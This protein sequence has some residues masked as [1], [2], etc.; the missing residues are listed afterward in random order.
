MRRHS[1]VK[2][3]FLVLFLSVCFV[4]FPG[5]STA[6][7]VITMNYSNFFPAPHKH[8]ILAEQWC[9]EIEKRTNG[10]VKIA[11]FPGGTLTPAAQIY[12]G[13]VKG[14]SDIGFSCFA[15]TRGKFPLTEVIDL[16]IG[17]KDGTTATRLI[18]EYYK[19]FKPKEIDEVKV[20]YLHAHGPGMLHTK[21]P[22][23]KLEDLKGMKI[24]ATG[25][26]SKI[27]TALGGSPVGT[28]MPETY[29]ALRTGV[30]EGAMAPFEALQ[31][32]KWGEVINSSTVAYG[33]GYSTGMFI[34]MNKNKWNSLPPDIQKVFTEVNEEWIEKQARAWDEIEKEGIDFTQKRGNKIIRLTKEEDARWAVAVKPIVD[35]YVK[36]TK[37]KG[38][39]GDEALKFCLDYLKANQK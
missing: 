28:T 29:D 19:K 13:V 26:A 18:N 32:F 5:Y 2:I 7:K 24:R 27:V 23:N 14:I 35:E 38:L 10:R 31:G 1:T 25:L 36:T 17:L 20:M 8:S 3:F 34:V 37:A 15:Y 30:A 4:S 33:S 22:V 6:Q 21:K 12:D 39:P 11:Y 16:P 9:K